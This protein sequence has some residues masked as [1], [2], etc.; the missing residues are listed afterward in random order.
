MGKSINPSDFTPQAIKYMTE[1]GQRSFCF[2]WIDLVKHK[3]EIDGAV[4]HVCP[5]CYKGA[6]AINTATK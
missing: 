4:Y 2:E 6:Q 3:L 5:T 1:C